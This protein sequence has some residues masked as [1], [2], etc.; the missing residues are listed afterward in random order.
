MP[1]EGDELLA[2]RED[3]ELAPFGTDNDLGERLLGPV[4]EQPLRP[5]PDTHERGAEAFDGKL[6][7]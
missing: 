4:E 7:S 1:A 5:V 6:E 3:L 2:P